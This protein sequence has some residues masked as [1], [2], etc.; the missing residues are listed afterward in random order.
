M[1]LL[2]QSL[3]FKRGP[4]F[5]PGVAGKDNQQ[6]ESRGASACGC[7]AEVGVINP[8]VFALAVVHDSTVIGFVIRSIG[9]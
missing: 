8:V 6:A 1:H 2:F 9:W 7:S 4:T 5:S 3:L